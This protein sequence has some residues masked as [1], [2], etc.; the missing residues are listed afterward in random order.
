MW[1]LQGQVRPTLRKFHGCKEDKDAEMFGARLRHHNQ[2]SRY[3]RR[4]KNATWTKL[5]QL[6]ALITDKLG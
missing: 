6:S 3:P 2:G 4:V 1:L 5:K